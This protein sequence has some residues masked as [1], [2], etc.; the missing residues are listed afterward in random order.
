MIVGDGPEQELLQRTARELGAGDRV[1]FFGYSAQVRALLPGFDI[2]ANSS[3]SEG[4][5]LTILEAMA[6]ALPVVA[7]RVGGTPE[8]V[9]EGTTGRMV[10]ARAPAEM[11][12]A[13]TGLATSP[14]ER[15]A[16]GRAGRGRVESAFTIDRMVDDYAREYQRLLPTAG[17]PA[18]RVPR[19]RR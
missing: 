14:A 17:A 12:A 5:S 8:V 1:R 13:L 10:G 3:V 19:S 18:P 9:I 11:A 6:A 7:T 4:V 15:L 16:L 2:Y